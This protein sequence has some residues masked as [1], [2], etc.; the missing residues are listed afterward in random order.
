MNQA[1]V[2]TDTLSYFFRGVP[3]VVAKLDTYL[4]EFGFINLSV[5]T[6]YE[7]L[8]GLYYKDAKKQMQKFEH[9]VALNHVLPLTEEI[10]EKSAK[11][12]ATLRKKGLVIGHNDILIA[13]T[14]LVNNLT[15][16]S[17]NISDFSKVESLKLDN[18]VNN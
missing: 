4:L 9:F 7:V 17:N 15:L 14:A 18:W 3:D 2:D 8:N 13:G 6:Y 5:V 1:I 11:I 10:A 16:I 12:H